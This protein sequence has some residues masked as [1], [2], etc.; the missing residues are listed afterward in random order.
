M[1]HYMI[2]L[3]LWILL[4]FII[5]CVIGYLLRRMF[6][7]K[8]PVTEERAVEPEP[9]RMMEPAVQAPVP[10]P[11]AES[12]MV[13]EKVVVSVPRMDRP[14]GLEEAR[15]GRPDQLQRIS[16]IGPKNEKIL[17]ALGFF[18]YD[19]IAAWTPEQI[20]WIDDHLKFNGRIGREEWIEQARLLAADKIDE[21]NARYGPKRK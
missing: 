21:F 10:E 13:V 9:V 1:T 4:L 15:S 12:V 2:E 7:S 14:R 16:G 3:A 20:A 18:H 19:Q 5:G 17:H 8:A 11:V 6:G